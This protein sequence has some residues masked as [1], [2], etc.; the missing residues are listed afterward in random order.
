MSINKIF[1]SIIRRRMVE[2][3]WMMQRPIESQRAVF[4][5]L[6]HGLQRTK[7]GCEHGLNKGLKSV[8]V[9]E[10]K[11]LIPIKTYDEIKPWISRSIAGESDV[12]WPG[13]VDWFAKT[14]GTTSDRSKLLPVTRESLRTGHYKGG[15]DLLAM[16]CNQKPKAKLY[17]GKHLIIGGS[18]KLSSTYTGALI[19]D[20]SAIII[21]N[22]PPWVEMR[23]TPSRQITM[24]E[25]WEEKIEL[26]AR[27]VI[28]EDV[29]ILA[30]IPSWMLV[31][32]NKV[33]EITGASSLDDVWPNLQLY[34]HGGV[35]FE[36]YRQ[37][38]NRMIKS[39]DIN[40]ME[41][42]NASEGFFA[43]QDSLDRD[44]MALLLDHGIFY[45][46]IPIHDLS[47]VNPDTLDLRELE[48]GEEYG[49]V[50]STNAGL[51]RYLVGD[52]IRLTSKDPYRI[53]VVGRLS[54]YLN[55]VGEELM[56]DQVEKAISIA[57]KKLNISIKEFTGAPKF[58][59]D[60]H[61][62]GHD[63]AVELFNKSNLDLISIKRFA[64]AFDIELKKVNSD[65]DAKRSS[66]LILKMPN[67]YVLENGAYDY[68]LKKNNK[69]GGQHKIPR[70]SNS[71][72]FIDEILRVI[73]N[74]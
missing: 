25:D 40:Y 22:L 35:G 13:K 24:L 37:E 57:A 65:Y 20:L 7:Y 14:S 19:G 6:V 4:L 53:K 47:T 71:R 63:W 15:R 3:D 41:T 54:S 72:A 49:L 18:A 60:G 58:A 26:M 29:R 52:V 42:Y 62:V 70:L 38:F 27:N 30:G 44:D 17:S 46:F 34:M 11:S 50:I 28:K 64:E 74:R 10:F 69:L 66:D 45:E 73:P 56:V 55:I 39:P 5:E 9:R 68:W 2:I 67:I 43:I 59:P 51:W 36:P 48:V 33:L 16:F 12:L 23:R 32:T 8:R 21:R 1:S 31:V 61:P